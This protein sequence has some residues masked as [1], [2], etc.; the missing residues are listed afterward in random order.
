MSN[1]MNS[2]YARLACATVVLLLGS[3]VGQ[4]KE[5]VLHNFSF[6]GVDG[7]YPQGSLVFDKA[8]NIYGTTSQ[9]GNSNYG[10]VFE[11]SPNGEGG[12]NFSDIYSFSGPDGAAPAAG[13]TFD[14]GGNLYGT[15]Q[16]GGAYNSGTVFELT[17]SPQGQWA[18]S[19]LYSFGAYQGDGILPLAGLVFDAAGNLYG[20]TY[21]GGSHGDC[22][23]NYG[24]GA[25]FELT[26][27]VAGQWNETILY[28]FAG[29]KKGDL[30]GTTLFGGAAGCQEYGCGTVFEL[31]LSE[32]GN[33]Q[34]KLLHRFQGRD[35]ASPAAGV[36]FDTAGNLYG[37]TQNGGDL[38][39]PS[40]IKGGGCGAVFRLSPNHPSGW[41]FDVLHEFGGVAKGDGSAPNSLTL[42]ANGTLYGSTYEGGV[43]TP[44]G[45]GT[46][47]ELK[48]SGGE[49]LEATFKAFGGTNGADPYSGVTLDR[50][51]NVYGTT[52]YSN[53]GAGVVFELTK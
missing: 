2:R 21:A 3:A 35:G 47:F 19:V 44:W 20:T 18:E 11:L 30:F 12:W 52:Y 46:V 7:A 6:S 41:S 33:W 5:V 23:H 40:A 27:S 48:Q 17:L 29:N 26:P 16:G 37:T 34:K 24:C 14:D 25:V 53:P 31:T 51:G 32:S 45:N 43:G 50:A 36:I 8:G 15:T 10:N 22:D 9:G 4:V 42:G 13:L 49:P 39:C 28:N 38:S 1:F